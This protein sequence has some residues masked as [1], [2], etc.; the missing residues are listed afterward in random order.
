MLKQR[1]YNIKPIVFN[2]LKI[3]QVIIDPHYEE[4]HAASISDM[5][6]LTLAKELDGRYESPGTRVGK[7]LY[8]AKLITL[9]NRQYRFVWLLEDRKTYIGIINVYRD[10]RRN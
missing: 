8:F 5:W 2:G 7:Y 1:V 6:I 9:N 10:K 4:K 3:S